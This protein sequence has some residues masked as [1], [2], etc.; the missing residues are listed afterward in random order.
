MSKPLK[1]FSSQLTRK[2]IIIVLVIMTII[3]V[4]AFGVTASGIYSSFRE[5]F[6]DA[7]ENISGNITENLKKVEISAANIADEITWHI[8]SP[9]DVI[10]TLTYEIE[11]NHNLI[12]CGMGFLP[13]YFPEEGKWFEPY[14]TFTDEGP[15]VK[16]IGSATHDYLEAE[17]FQSGLA[18]SGGVWSKPYAD[19]VG[20][21]TLLCTYSIPITSPEGKLAGTFGADLSLVW[22]GDLL[23][24]I[25]GRENEMGLLP[26][27]WKARDIKIYSFILGPQG[28]FIVHPDRERS[29][30]ARNYFDYA[31]ESKTDK[32][33]LLGEA[34]CSG[35]T[36]EEFVR[37]DGHRY[38]IYYAPVSDSGWSMAIVVP[39]KTLLRPAIAF[40]SAI[41]LLMLLGLTVVFRICHNA[42]KKFTEP[43]AQLADSATEVARGKFDAPLPEIRSQDEIGLLRDSFENMQQ[44]LSSYIAELTE[45]TAQK[46]SIEHELDIA[47]KIQMSMLPMIWPAFPDRKDIDI[48]GSITPAKAV[49]GDLYDFCIRDDKLFFCIGD[50]SGK[51]V[52]ASLVMAVIISMFRTLSTSGDGPEKLVSVINSATA[53]RNESLMFVTFF[54]GELNL[55]TRELKYCNAGHN[56]PYILSDGTPREL[57]ADANLPI[58]IEADWNYSLQETV[59]PPDS[60]LFL[61]TDGLTEATRA[62]GS[63]FREERVMS[64]LAG[65]PA[66]ASSKDLVGHMKEAV[67]AFVGDAEQ[68]DDL[69]ML[70]IKTV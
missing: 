15:S 29:I 58:G 45:T 14:A 16:D 28:E 43:L 32:Y 19:S 22:L 65:Q 62:D 25:D 69:T 37:M 13:D 52:P 39:L 41:L 3:S 56:V 30:Q 1:S 12:G 70:V 63:L 7:I 10:K 68:S 36:G 38:D 40:G 17:W 59:L 24:E 11:V 49:G 23:D 67:E 20:A 61:Y 51:G 47:R 55:E 27:F 44:S 54:V 57:Q 26:S 9:E 21:G 60:V 8:T 6:A 46:A 53:N 2:I 66:S 18:A 34:M 48:Y 5:H 33:R 64:C 35:K 31:G 50:V 4:L 42:V